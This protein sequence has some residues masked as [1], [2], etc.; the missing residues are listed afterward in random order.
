MIHAQFLRK[1][2]LFISFLLILSKSSFAQELV[3][4]NQVSGKTIKAKIGDQL[5]LVYQGYREKSEFY[6]HDIFAITDSSVFLG[7]DNRFVPLNRNSKFEK[8]GPSYKEI[9]LKDFV[10]FRRIS[11]GRKLLKQ[12]LKLG[13]VIGTFYVISDLID[14]NN[15]TR[16]QQFLV[17]IGI[18]I[19]ITYLVNTALPENPKYFM[20]EGWIVTTTK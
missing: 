6:I 18:G 5:S 2:C 8:N 17:S 3:F 16:T 12:T 10:K 20:N 19:G 4:I 15:L 7:I 9:L 13:S 14:K 11:V 1:I